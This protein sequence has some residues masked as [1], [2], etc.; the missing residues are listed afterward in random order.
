MTDVVSIKSRF[1]T[2]VMPFEAAKFYHIS[3]ISKHIFGRWGYMPLLPSLFT[4]EASEIVRES[5]PKEV[6]SMIEVQLSKISLPARYWYLGP[7]AKKVE[8]KGIERL[9]E[10]LEMGV[11]FVAAEPLFGEAEVIGVSLEILKELGIRD[12]RLTLGTHEYLKGLLADNVKGA[13]SKAALLK[14]DDEI[15]R[16]AKSFSTH[17]RCM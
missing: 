14:G 17:E 3:D 7:V 2:D 13:K 5:L 15:L 6:L 10:S 12:F 8:K 9:Q 4:H 11:E 16:Q 1:I